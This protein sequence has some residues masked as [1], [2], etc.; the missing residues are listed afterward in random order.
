MVAVRSPNIVSCYGVQTYPM[1]HGQELFYVLMEYCPGRCEG[2][3][4]R[5]VVLCVV[6]LFVVPSFPTHN[7]LHTYTSQVGTFFTMVA[8]LA[9]TVS[10][11][12]VS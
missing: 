10:P 4:M 7:A 2:V 6:A 3:H 9:K 11:N 8:K 12:L 1:A 5:A